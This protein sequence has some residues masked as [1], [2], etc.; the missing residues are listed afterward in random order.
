VATK[1]CPKLGDPVRHGSPKPDDQEPWL[2]HCASCHAARMGY[3][4]NHAGISTALQKHTDTMG[5][6]HSIHPEQSDSWAAAQAHILNLV[7]RYQ[8]AGAKFVQVRAH[9]DQD[10]PDMPFARTVVSVTALK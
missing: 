1:K 7:H 9:A 5:A 8:D 10:Q 6:A 3:C 2:K 4:H